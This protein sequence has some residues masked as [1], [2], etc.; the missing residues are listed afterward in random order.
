M[1]TN[2]GTTDRIIRAIVG[3]IIVVVGIVYQSLWGLVGLLPLIT[4][5]VGFCP[6]YTLLK[7][8]TI[9]KKK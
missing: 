1:R 6:L 2:I 5:A 8:D 4:S 3:I 7:F 9:G